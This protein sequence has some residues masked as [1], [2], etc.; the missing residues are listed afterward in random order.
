M[1]ELRLRL[2]RR[3]VAVLALLVGLVTAGVAYA[4]IPDGNGVLTAC[5]LNA[6]GT[7]RLIDP[8]LSGVLGR[9][10]ASL[11]TQITWNQ[12]GPKGPIG[13]KG[14]TGDKGA[15]GDKGPTG[16]AG[17]AGPPG[18]KGL[19]GDKGPTGDPG[20][21]GAGINGYDYVQASTSN[22]STHSKH[23]AALCP[24]GK[25]V[26]GGGYLIMPFPNNEIGVPMSLPASASSFDP[27]FEIPPGRTGWKADAVELV[28]TSTDWSLTVYA[29]CVA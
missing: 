14:P 16:D 3:A 23:I 4:T 5:K 17:P 21:A 10:S 25:K 11:E 20:P 19:A 29:I 28:D 26:T 9:C 2:S 12:G 18:E 6:T 13:D 1:M 27:R 15:S 24:E 22:D 8:S 7:I